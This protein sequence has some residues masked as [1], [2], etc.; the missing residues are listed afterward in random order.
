M[1][2]HILGIRHHG[3]GSA[4]NVRSMIEKIDP[5]IILVEGPPEGEA[6][7]QWIIHNEM[8]PPVAILAYRPDEPNQ[9]SFYPFAEFSPEWQALHYAVHNNIPVKFMDLPLSHSFA[10][11]KEEAGKKQEEKKLTEDEKQ[12]ERDPLLFLA[13]AAGYDDSELWWEHMF[14]QRM[15]DEACFEAVMEAMSALRTTLP[16]RKKRHEELREAWMRKVIRAAEKE[17]YKRIAVICGAWHGPSLLDMP[18]QK[19]DEE[20]LKKLPKVKVETTWIPWTYNRLT[21]ASG[22]GA[23]ILSPG[24]YHHLW[25]HPTDDGTRWMSQVAH[26]L[27]GKGMDTSTAHV[28]EG[29]RLAE[30]L[31]TLRERPRAGLHELTEATQSVLCNGEDTQLQLI[32]RELIV[33]NRLGRVPH[34]APKVPLQLD[35]EK[36]QKKL[37]LPPL[38]DPKE[39]QLDLREANDLARSILLHR[40]SLLGIEWGVAGTISG[41]G[42]FKE[43]WTLTWQPELTIRVIEMG[44]WGNTVEEAASKYVISTATE[45]STL[46]SLA[47][48]L[49]KTIPA[50]LPGAAEKLM[51]RLD[52]L[53]AVSSDILQLMEALPSLAYVSRYGNVRKTD[54]AFLNNIVKGLMI[55]I[56]IAL[57]VACQSLD[58]EAASGMVDHLSEVNGAM[59]LLKDKEMQEH[60]TSAMNKLSNG[61]NIVAGYATRLLYDQKAISDEEI[62]KRFSVALSAGNEPSHTAAWV[63]GFLRGSGM[64]LLLD[65]ALWSLLDKWVGSLNH[66]TFMQLLP[67]MRRTFAHF[68]PAERRKMGEKAKGMTGAAHSTGTSDDENFDHDRAKK[69]LTVIEQLLGMS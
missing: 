32:H 30:M 35:L 31:A 17:Q 24:W 56:S 22:Y 40:L 69:A 41:K 15:N 33:S 26:L 59:Q 34:D 14:E 57:P 27:R 48:M 7:L 25:E 53:A 9:A 60:W 19:E 2:I 44:A 28:I 13:R 42:T 21:F 61:N 66:E 38:P 36:L 16:E 68:T 46:P 67:L 50:E 51:E 8:K 58:E 18:K 12:A 54:L 52:H 6:L 64:I 62:E 5:D 4:R 65:S 39:Y 10:L 55:R 20:L 23:G 43:L 3:P 63:E 11:E 1:S 47:K 29:V 45:I 49:Q 37:R